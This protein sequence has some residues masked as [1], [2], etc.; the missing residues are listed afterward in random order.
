MSGSSPTAPGAPTGAT[1]VRG[2]KQATV[3]WTAPANTGHSQI[4][5][6]TVT[7]T[8][9][10]K[11][12]TVAWHG[13]ERHR[14]R[15]DQRHLVHL[16]GQGDERDRAEPGLGAVERG[17]AG[18]APEPDHHLPEAGEPGAHDA[19]DHGPAPT[20]TS[21]LPVT[22]ASTSPSICTVSGFTINLLAVGTCAVTA[23][24]A[25]DGTYKPAS[26][27]RTFTISLATAEDHLHQARQRDDL[28]DPAGD[29]RDDRLGPADHAD[30]EH[31]GGLQP[32]RRDVPPA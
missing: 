10:N 25:G 16:H 2:D 28:G 30:D 31:A 18:R 21:G 24:Q 8:P 15:P 5:G 9:G 32:C 4:T 13:D 27:N 14:H 29:H 20:S 17:D 1:A 19:V 3:S 22:L 7:S 12:A 26:L 6:Y 23:S 11:T